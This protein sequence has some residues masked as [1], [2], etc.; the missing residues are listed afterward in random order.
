MDNDTKTAIGRNIAKYRK[1][2]DLTQKD[3]GNMIGRR[4]GIISSWEK[5]IADPGSA[6]I[7]LLSNALHVTPNDLLGYISNENRRQIVM[8]DDSMEPQ[9]HKGDILTIETNTVP[10]DGDTV[11]ADTSKGKGLIR[12]LFRLGAQVML[13]SVNPSIPPIGVHYA[14]IKG[15]VTDIHRKL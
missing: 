10:A 12:R 4:Q 14:D 1:L 15:K 9:I 13:L 6:N 2:N 3:L 8:P 5:G 7:I 11:F